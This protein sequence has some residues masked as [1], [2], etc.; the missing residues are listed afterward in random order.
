MGRTHAKETSVGAL[1]AK[2]HVA[3]LQERD[4]QGE[5]IV[6]A[7]RGEPVAK[8]G[9]IDQAHDAEKAQEAMRWIRERAVDSGTR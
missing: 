9:P 1:G 8:L 2:T 5:E 4:H 3:A 7:R 6:I